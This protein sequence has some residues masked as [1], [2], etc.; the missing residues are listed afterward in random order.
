MCAVGKHFVSISMVLNDLLCLQ[1]NIQRVPAPF[2][3][4]LMP[5]KQNDPPGS[6]AFCVPA[7]TMFQC[8]PLLHQFFRGGR[9]PNDDPIMFPCEALGNAAHFFKLLFC[10]PVCR[11]PCGHGHPVMCCPQ[12]RRPEDNVLSYILAQIM[13][14]ADI[15][16]VRICLLILPTQIPCCFQNLSPYFLNFGKGFYARDANKRE[17]LSHFLRGK[18][19]VPNLHLQ[20]LFSGRGA[21]SEQVLARVQ[22]QPCDRPH[23]FVCDLCLHTSAFI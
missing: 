23:R 17:C 12:S 8:C 20:G 11:V 6:V 21:I 16:P 4:A 22:F 15:V 10:P 19:P 14:C 13:H 18:L 3:A 9:R 2:R 1:V 7:Y 5:N